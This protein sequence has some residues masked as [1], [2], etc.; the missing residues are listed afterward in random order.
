LSESEFSELK[1]KYYGDFPPE[2]PDFDKMDKKKP[3][4]VYRAKGLCLD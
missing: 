2:N 3:F 1:S 4:G